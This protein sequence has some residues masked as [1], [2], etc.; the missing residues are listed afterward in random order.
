M[1]LDGYGLVPTGMLVPSRGTIRTDLNADIRTQIGASMDLSDD[2]PFGQFV[3]LVC[4][5]LH[6]LWLLLLVLYKSADRDQASGAALEALC[7]L[8]GTLRDEELPSTAEVVLTGVPAT[9]VPGSTSFVKTTSTGVRFSI[10]EDATIAAVDAWVL[11]T[12]YVVGD[13]VHNAGL[14]FQCKTAGTSENGGDGPGFNI[15]TNGSGVAG[16]PL[17]VS[18]GTVVWWL[19]GIGTGAVDATATSEDK[20]PIIAVATDLNLIDTPVDGWQMVMNLADASLGRDVADDAELRADS[21][22]DVFRPGS[23]SPDAIRQ[24][25]RRLPGVETASVYFNPDSSPNAIGVPANSVECLVAGGD[26]DAIAA[27][28]FAGVCGGIGTFGNT[29]V[30]VEDSEGTEHDV[31]FSRPDDIEIYVEVTLE[32]VAAADAT[33]EIAAYPSDGDDQVAEEVVAKGNKLRHG[34]NVYGGKLGAAAEDVTGVLGVTQVR[35]RTSV[36]NPWATTPIDIDVR[37]R[38]RFDVS[39][40]T[41]LSSDG[42]V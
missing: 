15:G 26:E 2:D 38:A 5:R 32:K 13:R 14:V 16:E 22:E 30:V 25:L 17:N 24:E 29:T 33:D 7:M 39:R 11:N 12:A 31:L 42:D 18:D 37:E 19:I 4:D 23:G 27:V 6:L 34:G 21:D 9:V 20:G 35:M 28:I 10:D 40:V 1:A 41:V 3:G 36:L 8:T